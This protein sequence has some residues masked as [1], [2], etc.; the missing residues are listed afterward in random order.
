MNTYNKPH[1]KPLKASS[2]FTLIE[3]MI[4]IAIIG[5]LMAYAVP[6]YQSYTIRASAGECLSM[7]S[8]A[9]IAVSSVWST[10]NNL[11]VIN[12]NDD[13]LIGNILVGNNVAS[14]EVIPNGRIVC[15]F[16]ANVNALSAQTITLTPTE[17]QG[18]LSWACTSS[19]ANPAYRPGNCSL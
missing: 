19:I 14:I 7:M 6:A 9:K 18:S 4:V 17:G 15:T 2:G 10:T 16:N 3:L 1:K 8:D 5:I 12:N 11:G 13:A